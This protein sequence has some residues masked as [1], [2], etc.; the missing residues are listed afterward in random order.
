MDG[1]GNCAVLAAERQSIVE[2]GHQ[3]MTTFRDG[4]FDLEDRGMSFRERV[5]KF[6]N[7]RFA[8]GCALFKNLWLHDENTTS[9]E[10]KLKHFNEWDNEMRTLNVWVDMLWLT[11]LAAKKDA[12]HQPNLLSIMK[13]TGC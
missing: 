1:S 12:Q 13:K 10:R 7:E 2:E 6:A 9:N 5:S 8:K 3:A 11:T 4:V